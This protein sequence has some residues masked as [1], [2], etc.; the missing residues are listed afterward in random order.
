MSKHSEDL[1]GRPARTL[2]ESDLAQFTS[3]EHLYRHALVR[4]IRFT[5]GILYVAEAGGA[6]WLLDLIACAQLEPT[7]AAE[8]FQFW[9]LRVF[10]DESGELSCTDGNGNGNLLKLEEIDYTDFPMKKI[11]IYC[12]DNTILL[13]SEY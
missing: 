12:T 9:T 6:H 4:H 8:P 2:T 7:V 10:E 13:P 3:T 1:D 11:E 5:D